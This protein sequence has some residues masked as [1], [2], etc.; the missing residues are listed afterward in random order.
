MGHSADN[1]RPS[2]AFLGEIGA[3]VP[4]FRTKPLPGW[5]DSAR[6][7]AFQCATHHLR[8]WARTVDLL[9]TGIRSAQRPLTR[10]R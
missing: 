10:S 6:A 4:R 8:T 2:K 5:A 3:G 9:P 7:G 1:F